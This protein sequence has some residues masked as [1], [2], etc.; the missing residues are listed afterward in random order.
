[1][2]SGVHRRC[3]AITAESTGYQNLN[4]KRKGLGSLLCRTRSS[5]TAEIARVGD[6]YTVQDYLRTLILIP[7][8]STYATMGYMSVADSMASTNLV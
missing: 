1:V 6:H 7:I 4:H 5:A 2:T 3:N 8:E